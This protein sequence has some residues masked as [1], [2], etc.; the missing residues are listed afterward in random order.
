MHHA[1]VQSEQWQLLAPANGHACTSAPASAGLLLCSFS[2]PVDRLDL[3]ARTP[4]CWCGLRCG[5]DVVASKVRAR[6]EEAPGPAL[7]LSSARTQHGQR[8]GAASYATL[9]IDRSATTEQRCVP[10]CWLRPAAAGALFMLQAEA[11]PA[12]V[13][14]HR[15]R[16]HRRRALP[17]QSPVVCAVPTACARA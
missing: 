15:P 4:P 8:A 6:G 10:Q 2:G 17:P 13:A 11:G 14:R 7:T 1:A 16:Q 9:H 5:V 12:T 3:I